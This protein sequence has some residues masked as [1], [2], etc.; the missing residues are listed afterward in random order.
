VSTVAVMM[1]NRMFSGVPIA[2]IQTVFFS[3]VQKYGSCSIAR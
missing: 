2:M 1:A 3:D